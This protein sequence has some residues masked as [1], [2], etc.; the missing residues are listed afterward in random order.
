MKIYILILSI[1]LSSSLNAQVEFKVQIS[2]DAVM[3]GEPFII[4]YEIN[5]K[6]DDFKLPEIDNFKLI[7]GPTTYR[8][9]V[10]KMVN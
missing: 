10:M 4:E 9:Q 3:I 5:Q 2:K 7:S 6:F 8:Q 1:G